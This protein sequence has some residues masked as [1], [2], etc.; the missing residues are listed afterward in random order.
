MLYAIYCSLSSSYNYINENNV[1]ENDGT[2]I[3]L[4]KSSNNCTISSNHIINNFEGIC[5]KNIKHT[6]IANNYI[7]NNS[8]NGIQLGDMIT[9]HASSNN[10]IIKNIIKSNQ[11]AGLLFD[12]QSINNTVVNNTFTENYY[13]I[14]LFFASDHNQL[15]HNT[16]MNNTQSASDNCVNFWDN[17]NQT[18]GNYW[19]DY[20]GS[21]EDQDGFGDDPYPIAGNGNNFDNYPL[22]QPLLNTTENQLPIVSFS[23]SP[24]TPSCK[25]MISFTDESTDPDGSL[26]AWKWHFGDDNT[27]VVK[28]PTHQYAKSGSYIVTLTVTDNNNTKNSTSQTID[29]STGIPHAQF[30]YT[31]QNPTIEDTMTFTDKSTDSDGTITSWHWD[32]ADGSDSTLQNPTHQYSSPGEYN[33]TLTITDDDELQNS[34]YSIITVEDINYPPTASF[35][36]NPTN[37]FTNDNIRFESTSTDDGTIQNYTWNMDDGTKRYGE[38]ITYTFTDS[39]TYDVR[40]KVTDDKGATD[41]K[42]KSVS[43]KPHISIEIVSPSQQEIVSD[44]IIIRGTAF[45]RE[46]IKTVQLKIDNGQYKE[47]TGLRDWRYSLDTTQY[48][49]GDLTIVAQCIDSN[50]DSTS[51]SVRV[52]VENTADNEKPSIEITYPA[53]NIAL[54]ENITITGR[55][56]DTD[57]S[58]D[59]VEIRIDQGAWQS[60][61]ITN[62]VWEFPLNIYSLISGE[63]QIYARSYDGNDYSDI[64]SVK[65]TIQFDE[66]TS[67]DSTSDDTDSDTTEPNDSDEKNGETDTQANNEMM[68]F[69]VVISTAVMAVIGAVIFIIRI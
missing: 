46:D 25:D 50:G 65:I 56:K 34:T 43:V 53:G 40:L 32:F 5:L 61:D 52:T 62:D 19:D 22:M 21:D 54:T 10:T 59:E 51:D 1:I 16:F 39:G 36:I 20:T 45:A 15:F 24:E 8:Q 27:S 3:Y 44:T 13:P 42:T 57:G 33:V 14:R 38:S 66:N 49:N 17:G 68:I 6:T 63:H 60:V 41:A 18:G 29:V 31:P 4:E 2:G 37:P 30:E 7:I 35:T 47:V 55:A 12:F 48:D 64:D 11:N 23:Y 9:E 58:I 67:D 26:I 28:N 69:L